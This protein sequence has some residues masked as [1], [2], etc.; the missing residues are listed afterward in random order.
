MFFEINKYFVNDC[1]F[2]TVNHVETG[3]QSDKRMVFI[4]HKMLENKETQL[5][6]AYKMARQG[7]YCVLPDMYGHGERTNGFDLSERYDF[8][9]IYE[10]IYKTASDVPLIV[11]FIKNKE[12]DKLF[13]EICGVGVSIGA[14]IAL[15]SACFIPMK[16]IVSVI[17]IPCCWVSQIHDNIFDSYKMYSKIKK[18]ID[19]QKLLK[20]SQKYDPLNFIKNSRELPYVLMING[21]MDIAMPLKIVRQAY[22][23]LTEVYEKKTERLSQKYIPRAGHFFT[24]NMQSI[25]IKYINDIF[26]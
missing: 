26:K 11:D 1:P 23:R 19:V 3:C 5:P 7:Y 6:L 20:D 22:D 4:F 16:C 8:N 21:K 15:L 12:K 9:D 25:T 14:S 13:S 17:G 10:D 24:E 18:G 2:L